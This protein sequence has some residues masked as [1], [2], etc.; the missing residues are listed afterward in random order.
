MVTYIRRN[1]VSMVG[2]DQIAAPAGPSWV[3]PFELARWGTGSSGIVWVFQSLSPF[4][5]S[6]A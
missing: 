2:V 5:A 6:T 4:E 1:L 3:T